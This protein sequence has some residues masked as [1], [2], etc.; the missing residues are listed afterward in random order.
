[1]TF[2][3]QA[4]LVLLSIGGISGMLLS[5]ALDKPKGWFAIKQISRLR[6]GHVDAL[7]IGTVL[8]AL[9]YGATMLHP[10]IGWLLIVSGFYTA[11]GTGA[12]AWWPDWPTRTRLVWWLDFCSLSTFA[13]GLTAAAV[14]SFLY[15]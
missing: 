11:I 9:G 7:I 2:I 14:S 3:T 8:L 6:Q 10:A 1:M 12:L 15:S 4:G 13:F 5:V